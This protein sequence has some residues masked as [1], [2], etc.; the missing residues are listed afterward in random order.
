[1][2]KIDTDWSKLIYNIITIYQS[3]ST[4]D[5]QKPSYLSYIMSILN[6]RSSLKTY[7]NK[8]FSD[9]DGL[10]NPDQYHIVYDKEFNLYRTHA[11]VS[12]FYQ[13]EDGVRKPL[14]QSSLWAEIL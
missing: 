1:M 7:I 11:S 14:Q 5:E 10:A 6:H 9:I 8:G 4:K 13:E 3:I 12:L 2:R